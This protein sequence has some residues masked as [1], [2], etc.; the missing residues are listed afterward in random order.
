M[1]AG[2]GSSAGTQ[3]VNGGGV[4]PYVVGFDAGIGGYLGG[5]GS[6]MGATG[7]A[8]VPTNLIGA[9]LGLAA[10]VPCLFSHGHC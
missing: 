9:G 2:G 4:D 7:L 1:A 6:A 10:S 3:L 8:D 5:V